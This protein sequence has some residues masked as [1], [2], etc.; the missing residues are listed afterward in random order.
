MQHVEQKQILKPEWRNDKQQK[1]K[2]AHKRK[3][4]K[5]EKKK[6]KQEPFFRSNKR[7]VHTKKCY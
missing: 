1:K 3:G 5:R 7:P 4:L 2:E 6:I